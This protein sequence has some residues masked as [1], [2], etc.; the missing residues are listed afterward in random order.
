MVDSTV[1]EPFIYLVSGVLK[2]WHLLIH[3]L[4]GVNDSTAWALSLL[5]LV[6]TVRGLITPIS[7]IQYL[8]SRRSIVMRPELEALNKEYESR[9]DKESVAELEVKRKELRQR[10][11]Y[12]PM[13]GCLPML[14]Q[15]PIFLG[16]YRVVVQMSRPSE[17]LEVPEGASVGLLNATE[18]RSFINAE[19]FGYPLPA[20]VAMSEEHLAALGTTRS[21]VMQ[22]VLPTLLL[23]VFFTMFNLFQTVRRNRLTMDWS[24]KLSRGANKMIVFM[25]PFI[26]V[27]LISFGLTGQA[28]VAII[29]YWFANNLWTLAQTSYIRFRID[30]LMPLSDVHL[31]ATDEAKEAF[32]SDLRERRAHRRAVRRRKAT[33]AI[34]PWK[35]PEIRRELKAENAERREKATA[36]KAERKRI[37][38]EQSAARTELIKE[39]NERKRQARLAKKNPDAAAKLNNPPEEPATSDEP[40]PEPSPTD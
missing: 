35:I 19:L 22:F 29:A 40:N 28:P 36:E 18:M 24:S 3:N 21:E 8:S 11:N 14:I 27:M 39:K 4:L 10:H 26:P 34:K 9:T 20:Y 31:A 37:R 16:L 33:G 2:L 30:Q 15:I 13:A 6:I 7:W 23:A 38:K 1:L 25:I 17:T 12:N 5:G 32:L